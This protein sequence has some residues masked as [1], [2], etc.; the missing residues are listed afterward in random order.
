MLDN[1]A[2]QLNISILTTTIISLYGV[3]FLMFVCRKIPEKLFAMVKRQFTVTVTITNKDVCFYNLLSEFGESSLSNKSRTVKFINGDTGI[4]FKINKTLGMGH[5]FCM[6]KNIP[7][8]ITLLD[9]GSADNSGQRNIQE[10]YVISITTLGRSHR[11]IDM[12]RKNLQFRLDE[13]RSCKEI[14]AWRARIERFEIIGELPYR[15]FNTIFIDDVIKNKLITTIDKF[16]NDK[17]WYIDHG[18]NYKLGILLYGPPGTGKTSIIRAIATYLKRDIFLLSVSKL[19]DISNMLCAMYSYSGDKIACVEDIDTNSIV[20]DRNLTNGGIDYKKSGM[21]E[22]LN[23]MDGIVTQSGQILIYT[24]NHIENIDPAIFR[25]GRI[26]LKLYIGYMSKQTFTAYI[27][28]L[29]STNI[30][31]DNRVTMKDV[32]PAQI[33]NDFL[34][35][36]P[37]DSII[38]K[39]TEMTELK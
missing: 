13:I 22:I 24:S 10:R 9:K 15:K 4:S 14:Y 35:G 25:P 31:L 5:H 26:D 34:I 36:E 20:R 38:S 2:E 21:S 7:M 32:T 16:E 18:I 30:I 19:D 39:Y 33:Q 8:F 28:N 23:A 27:N 11:A 12:L 17:Q 6:Y 1:I 37:V 3:G 29:Y